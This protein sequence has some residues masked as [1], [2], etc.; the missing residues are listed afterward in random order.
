MV[1]R[2]ARGRPPLSGAGL[3]WGP[4]LPRPDSNQQEERKNSGHLTVLCDEGNEV[5]GVVVEWGLC[6]CV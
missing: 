3:A 2:P 1:C 5:M 6:V 4:F